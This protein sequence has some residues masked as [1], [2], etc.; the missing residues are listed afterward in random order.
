MASSQI[1]P[2]STALSSLGTPSAVLLAL[3][4]FVAM[5]VVLLVVIRVTV[6]AMRPGARWLDARLARRVTH[7][8]DPAGERAEAIERGA[9]EWLLVGFAGLAVLACGGALIWLA[10][11]V[12]ADTAF[13]SVDH[14]V[15]ATLQTL[16]HGWLD[17]AMVIVTEIGGG[18]VSLAVA[19]SV[20]AWLAWRRAW[21]A[22]G[23]WVGALIGARACVLMLK[24]AIARGRPASIYAGLESF[25]FPSGHATS[26]MVT[27]GF[28]AVLLC[29]RQRWRIRVPVLTLT[30]VTIT[31]IGLSRLY[32]GMHW[33]SDVLAGYALGLAWIA[34]LGTA[35]VTLHRPER[36]APLRLGAVA[37]AVALLVLAWF[38]AERLSATLDRYRDAVSRPA[39]QSTPACCAPLA[40]PVTGRSCDGRCP[41]PRNDSPR[42]R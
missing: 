28:L 3:G 15:F 36:L 13:V 10:R 37:C 25:S 16:R 1:L 7:V 23:Y 19:V 31:L 4:A 42:F 30:M 14:A 12:V 34:M 27:Y 38:A 40:T 22:A 6:L 18:R 35:Y 26:S 39:S 5:T 2:A 9:L 24:L 8:A 20:L 17:T 29:A 41:A 33:L 21:V 11:E 32:L